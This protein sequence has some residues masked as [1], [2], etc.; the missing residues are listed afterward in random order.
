MKLNK[1]KKLGQSLLMLSAVALMPVTQAIASGTHTVQSGEW[2]WGIARQYGVTADDI[3]AA[4]GLSSDWIDVGTVLTI[5]SAGYASDTYYDYG[6]S[7]GSST[8]VHTVSAGETLDGIAR[9]Y[10]VTVAELMAWNGL[11]SSWIDVGD[12]LALYGD[13]YIPSYDYSYDYSYSGLTYGNAYTIQPGDTL[14]G[15]AAVYGVSVSELMAMNGLGSDWLVAGNSISVPTGPV[16]YTA[17]SATTAQTA[18]DGAHIVQSGDMLSSIALTYG[19]TV[20]ELRAWNNLSSDWLE[21]GDVIYVVPT[22]GPVNT[23][24]TETTTEETTDTTEETTEET[25]METQGRVINLADLPEAARPEIHT[26]QTGENVWRIA[27]LYN[28]SADSLRN[29]NNLENDAIL[30]GQ[31]LFVSNPALIPEI[32]HVEE[33]ENL[34]TIAMDYNTTEQLIIEWNELETNEVVEGDVLVVSDPRPETHEVEPG[35]TLEQV[36][37]QFGITLDE[38][39]SWNGIPETV[40]IV[41]GTLIVSNPTGTDSEPVTAEESD[42]ATESTDSSAEAESSSDESAE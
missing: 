24:P 20:D 7:Y 18:V 27:E 34:Y 42:S 33:G 4:N 9:A 11:S 23:T 36:A 26:V 14:S 19:V 3:K 21:V 32:H 2:L 22:G 15:I 12:Q 31:Q 40:T 38:L 6:Y 25:T 8:G 5:P 41:N 28:I 17:P 35:Q 37:E 10:S 16:D 29:W 39:R 13:A 30:V 1:F